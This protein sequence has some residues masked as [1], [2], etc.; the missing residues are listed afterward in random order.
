MHCGSTAHRYIVR[1]I[2]ARVTD[3]AFCARATDPG[4]GAPEG[5]PAVGAVGRNKTKGPNFNLPFLLPFAAPGAGAGG[6]GR[7][8]EGVAVGTKCSKGNTVKGTPVNLPVLVPFAAPGAGAGS[9]GCARGGARGG[10]GGRRRRGH[11]LCLRAPTAACAGGARRRGGGYDDA[12]PAVQGS[13]QFNLCV[14]NLLQHTPPAASEVLNKLSRQNSAAPMYAAAA[15]C[16]VW[17]P[18]TL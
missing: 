6:G 1:K 16:T 7:A 5:A 4:A 3:P 15:I 14:F 2:D 8:R 11:G 12:R 9:G 13:N 18:A 17:S 10:H